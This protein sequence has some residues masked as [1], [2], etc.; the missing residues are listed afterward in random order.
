MLMYVEA[1]DDIG[2]AIVADVHNLERES[3][4]LSKQNNWVST[5]PFT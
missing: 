3:N 2:V 4:R 5:M 1:E